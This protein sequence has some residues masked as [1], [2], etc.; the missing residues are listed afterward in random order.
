[1]SQDQ[2]MIANLEAHTGKPI[3]HW[4]DVLS[5]SGLEK[6]GQLVKHLKEDHDFTHGYANL[7]AHLHRQKKEG[8]ATGDDL[9]DAQYQGKESLRPVYDRILEA[10]QAFG[11]DVEIAPKKAYVSL[12]RSKQ[13]GL[14][15]PSTKSR[16]DVGLNLGDTATTDRLEASGSFNSM[17]SHRVRLS[18]AGDVDDQLIGW[19]RAAY[20]QS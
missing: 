17:V 8:A 2:T 5:R 16:V 9:V 20:D 12:R 4:L 7:V 19:L 3:R 14:V 1:M 15:Q 13:F 11:S 18:D 10:V 6:H